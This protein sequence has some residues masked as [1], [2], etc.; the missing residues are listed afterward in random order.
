MKKKKPSE[1]KPKIETTE[2]RLENLFNFEKQIEVDSFGF[3]IPAIQRNYTWGFGSESDESMDDSAWR[4]LKDLIDFHDADEE[5]LDTYFLGTVILFRLTGQPRLQIMDGQQRMTSLVALMSMIRHMRE[6][7]GKTG[8]L[9]DSI[10]NEQEALEWA[11]EVRVD[12][13]EYN[14]MLSLTPKVE[15]DKQTLEELLNLPGW[16]DPSDIEESQQH[17]LPRGNMYNP[18]TGFHGSYLYLA[19]QG[20]WDMLRDR[21]DLNRDGEIDTEEL[22]ELIKFYDT[23]RYRVV[24]N[25]TITPDIGLAYRMFVTAN[26]RGKPL[27]NFDLFRGLIQARGYELG[28][29][30]DQTNMMESELEA[31]D[32]NLIQA[33]DRIWGSKADDKKSGEIDQIMAYSASVREGRVIAA[34]NVSSTFEREIRDTLTSYEEVIDLIDFTKKFIKHWNDVDEIKRREG[35]SD[36]FAPEFLISRRFQRLGISQHLPYL[37][38]MN[39]CNWEREEIYQFL[40]LIEC[41]V[42]RT[43]IAGAK[44]VG[45]DMYGLMKFAKS[46]YL[47]SNRKDVIDELREHLIDKGHNKNP[48]GWSSL[49][50]TNLKQKAA[51]VLLHAVDEKLSHDPGPRTTNLHSKQLLPRYNWGAGLEA[52]GWKYTQKEKYS[53]GYHSAKIGNW[54]LVRGNGSE[55]DMYKHSEPYVKISK[56]KEFG[57]STTLSALEEIEDSWEAANIKDRTEDLIT[58]FTFFYPDNYINNKKKP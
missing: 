28:F 20:Y 47:G 27:N 10:G 7:Y 1:Y 49:A 37:T 42:M 32:N 46:I 23:L 54:F 31:C 34:K 57:V 5:G 26:T 56:W 45:G 40:W 11:D 48:E 50:T 4:L 14:G 3:D 33:V 16:L 36:R 55:I 18:R 39:V 53:E 44:S 17:L 43:M 25:R 9:K 52:K 51:Y 58:R 6:F 13:L 15:D 19:A 2:V 24:V 21:F 22:E 41:F 35:D 29:T 8:L 30:L 38:V 12:F